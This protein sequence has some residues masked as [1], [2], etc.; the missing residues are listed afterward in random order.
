MHGTDFI[1]AFSP[2]HPAK[3]RDRHSPISGGMDR[4]QA[5]ASGGP[6]I[7]VDVAIRGEE[8]EASGNHENDSK[9]WGN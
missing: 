2:G 6:V 9:V 4:G 8:G 3:F 7:P 5:S 1:W